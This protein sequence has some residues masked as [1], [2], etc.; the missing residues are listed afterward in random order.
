MD[1][2]SSSAGGGR[3]TSVPDGGGNIGRTD[4]LAR[5]SL[6]DLADL[7]HAS[8]TRD[9]QCLAFADTVPATVP[10]QGE[11]QRLA[12]L[13]VE[14]IRAEFGN[15]AAA[16][17]RLSAPSATLRRDGPMWMA[18]YEGRTIRLRNCRGLAF[19]R[20]LLHHPGDRIHCIALEAIVD[21]Y[22][23]GP[24]ESWHDIA[25]ATIEENGMRAPCDTDARATLESICRGERSPEF[26]R[27]VERARLNVSRA[28]AAAL[29]NIEANHPALGM[30]LR[31]TVRLGAF[32]VYLPDPRVPMQWAT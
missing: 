1:R 23:L 3:G 9:L 29:R 10:P 14:R 19:L 5:V 18:V 6:L 31:A 21:R 27:E 28:I 26:Q 2:S 7:L 20:T 13:L 25:A 17:Q 24:T 8:A 11:T 12:L 30:H 32:C 22:K 15:G 16:P 4:S